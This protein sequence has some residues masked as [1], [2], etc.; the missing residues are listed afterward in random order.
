MTDETTDILDA[1][2][3][4]S[5]PLQAAELIADEASEDAAEVG[6]RLRADGHGGR[7]LAPPGRIAAVVARQQPG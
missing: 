7:H 6:A 2:A 4:A 3:D 1:A 5:L